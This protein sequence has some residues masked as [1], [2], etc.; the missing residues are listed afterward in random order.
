MAEILKEISQHY[1]MWTQDME[2]RLNRKGGWNDITDAYYGKLPN[3]WPY[4]TRIVDPVLRT[5]L[6]EK[7]G[8]LINS[9]LRGRLVPREG[10][11]TI[12]AQINNA[13][14]DFQWES[15]NDG[16]SMQTKMS[17]SDMD[18]RLYQSKFAYV[19]WRVEKDNDGE[20][21]FEGNEMY[22]LDIRDCGIDPTAN[23]IRDAKW[24]QLREWAKVEDLEN[25][26]DASGKPIYKNLSKLKTKLSEKLGQKRSTTRNTEYIARVKQ[27]RGL[28]DRTGEDMAFPVVKIATE[29]RT[30]RWVTF[31]PDYDIIL[32]DIKNPYDHGRIPIAQL[33]YYPLQDD[34]LGES[35]AEPV[36][37]LWKAIQATVCAYMDEVILKIR[38]P[39]KI[40]E[41]ATRVETIQYGP[42][43]QWIV[44]RQDAIEEMSSGGNT[45]AF[46]QTTYQALKAAFN[47]A[48][49]DMSQGISNF[50]PFADDDKTATEIRATTRQQ[51]NRDQ[52]N[53][54][55]LA[56]FIKDIMMMWL[57][58]NQQFLFSDP[59]KQEHIIRIIGQEQYNYF[60]RAGLDGTEIDPA[61]MQ[62]IGDIIQQSPDMTDSEIEVLHETASM[63]KFPVFDN[64]NEKDPTKINAKTKMRINDTDDS[65]EV[66]IVPKDLEGTYDYVPDVKSMSMGAGEELA[67]ARQQAIALFTSNP[68]VLQLLQQDGYRPNVKELL[69][70]TLEGLGLTDSERFFSKIDVQGP[71]QNTNGQ[72]GGTPQAMGVEGLPGVSQA[73]VGG[74]VPE[75]MAGPVGIQ[76]PGGIS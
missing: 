2:K 50:G 40:I 62:M 64:P 33:R 22:P 75:Q 44:D 69:R 72:M 73:P 38:P 49:G 68:V 31:A 24:F 3:D 21:V 36:L 71:T 41:N 56:E 45:L 30:D 13:L 26:L 57:S 18:A 47:V 17:I 23:H 5:S 39:L 25:Q 20:L 65:A 32:R 7:N 19:M 52:K 1:E 35:E 54:N 6:I 46:F 43:A 67:Q 27:L 28:E 76:V 63:P 37:P 42:G 58:N 12:G 70:S 16:G 9:K 53:Q 55:D 61:A 14:L 15:A 8:R 4:T 59:D 60:K 11:D 51:N 10:A 66:S 48:M 29:F 34:P 74:G